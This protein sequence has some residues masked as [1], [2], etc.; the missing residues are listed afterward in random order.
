MGKESQAFINVL[1]WYG[2]NNIGDESYKLSFPKLFPQHKLTFSD[3][4]QEGAAA[5]ILGGGDVVSEPFL[6]P[7]EKFTKKHILSASISK[8]NKNINGFSTIAVRDM[9]SIS[10]AA[11]SG[12]SASYV[13]DFA[14][15]FDF[16]KNR[17]QQLIK[18]HFKEAELYSQVVA[19]VINSNMAFEQ[20]GVPL[21]AK[22]ICQFEH[23]SFQ[24]AQL[25]DNTSASFLFLPFGS[26]S[27]WDDRVTN[28]WTASKC[29]FYKKNSVVYNRLSV[30]DTIDIISACNAVVSTRLHSSIFSCVTG[31]PFIDIVHNH[32]NQGFLDTIRMNKLGIQYGQACFENMNEHMKAVLENSTIRD[33]LVKITTKQK[34][35]LKEFS[36][37]VK[38]V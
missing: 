10:N 3:T 9:F 19:I 27:P 7:L 25:I 20:S 18:E 1:G 14:F 26:A 30:Q 22:N 15:A 38:L 32:K 8:V 36:Q 34:L 4:P 31:T 23:F 11:A 17:G 13:P 35:I 33:E 5:Y 2:H 12:V 16:D 37:Y 6:K 29:K 24:L 21:I 28:G